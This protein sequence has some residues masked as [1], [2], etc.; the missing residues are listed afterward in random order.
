MN[1]NTTGNKNS[2]ATASSTI[3]SR[4][5][6]QVEQ[7]EGRINIL[8]Y[9]KSAD[10]TYRAK[11][12]FQDAENTAATGIWS[13]PTKLLIVESELREKASTFLSESD[14]LWAETDYR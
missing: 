7:I 5:G 2:V 13:T 9:F 14:K 12:F 6:Q 4:S 8:R 11:H 10:L 1:P 3:T